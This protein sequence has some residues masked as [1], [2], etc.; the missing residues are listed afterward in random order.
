MTDP[1]YGV[2]LGKKARAAKMS[3]HGNAGYADTDDSVEFVTS[4][5]VPIVDAM[6]QRCDRVVLTPGSANLFCYPRPDALWAL[7]WP[8][9]AGI[10]RWKSFTCW[11]PVLCYGESP[12]RQGCFPDTFQTTEQAEKNGHPCP[13]PLK[14]WTNIMDRI[15]DVPEIIDPFLGSAT[16]GH[17]ETERAGTGKQVETTH[18]LPAVMLQVIEPVEHRFTH[19]IRRRTQAIDI[20]D[21]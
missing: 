7:Y 17:L 3:K 8:N 11:Q 12:P 21:G 4:V 10:G 6:R 5:C 9:G 1:P 20:G 19:T 18:G 14:L 2:G 13:K 16:T 15:G